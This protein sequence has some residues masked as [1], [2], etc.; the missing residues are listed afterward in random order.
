M[1]WQNPSR[2]V[3]IL[4]RPKAPPTPRPPKV[5]SEA[6]WIDVNTKA[7]RALIKARRELWRSTWCPCHSGEFNPGEIPAS[8]SVIKKELENSKVYWCKGCLDF[9]PTRVNLKKKP[10]THKLWC[11]GCGGDSGKEMGKG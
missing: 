5:P 2:T 11:V 6:K 7:K 10:K 4:K 3:A 1:A 8:L 9:L